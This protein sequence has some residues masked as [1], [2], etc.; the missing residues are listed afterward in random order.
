MKSEPFVPDHYVP[1]SDQAQQR[2]FD[3]LECYATEMR[4]DPHP[5]S[6]N[7]V[8]ILQQLRGS[9]VG[10]FAA[11]AFSTKFTIGL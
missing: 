1:L 11:E 2:K 5:R 7:T 10:V 4:A 8:A 3:A 6:Y 9:T